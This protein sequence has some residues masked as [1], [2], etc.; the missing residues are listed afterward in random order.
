MYLYSDIHMYFMK[1]GS[2]TI[3]PYFE[4]YYIY[5]YFYLAQI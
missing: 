1:S 3:S 5:A 4:K 2:H